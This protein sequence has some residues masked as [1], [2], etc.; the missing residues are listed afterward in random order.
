LT[1]PKMDIVRPIF[2]RKTMEGV[3]CELIVYDGAKHGFAVRAGQ[4]ET[5]VRQMHE[6]REQGVK[7]FQKHLAVARTSK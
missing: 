4:G 5:Q 1:P 7:F 3:E 6:A 2:E